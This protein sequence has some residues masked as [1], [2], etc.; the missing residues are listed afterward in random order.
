MRVTTYDTA[1]WVK[2]YFGVTLATVV[3]DSMTCHSIMKE[4]ETRAIGVTTSVEVFNQ[5][6]DTYA[7]LYE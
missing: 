3:W 5:I 2:P 6:I 7:P 4:A 1:T